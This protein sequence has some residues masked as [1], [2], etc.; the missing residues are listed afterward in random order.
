MR[1]LG[2]FLLFVSYAVFADAFPPPARVV[3]RCQVQG[4]VVYT[5]DPCPDAK[6]VDATPTRGVDSLSGHVRTGRDVHNEQFNEKLGE[7]MRPFGSSPEKFKTDVRRIHL[8]NSA[9]IEC[10]ILEHSIPEAE[11]RSASESS[12]QAS[13]KLFKLRQRYRGLR[14]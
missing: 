2:G 10:S 5:D 6:V 7:A 13:E 4:R 8:S 1:I 12:P 14:C 9:K 11:A 3:Y